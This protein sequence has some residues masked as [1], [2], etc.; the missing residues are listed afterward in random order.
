MKRSSLIILAM[1]A[2]LAGCNGG[3]ETMKDEN[4]SLSV[5]GVSDREARVKIVPS[6]TNVYYWWDVETEEWF[7]EHKDSIG[8][9]YKRQWDEA[10]R[11]GWYEPE[12]G[13]EEEEDGIDLTQGGNITVEDFMYKGVEKEDLDALRPETEYVLFAYYPDADYHASAITVL[14]F[15]TAKAEMVDDMRIW[16]MPKG[17]NLHINLSIVAYDE[18]FY[19]SVSTRD[20]GS[21]S[22][23]EYAEQY[24]SSNIGKIRTETE[25]GIISFMADV[26]IPEDETEWFACSYIEKTRTSKWYFYHTPTK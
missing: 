4:F 14:P 2:V 16:F 23:E 5:S 7:R 17:D 1:A 22:I 21:A 10:I 15:R 9:Y 13:E 8:E 24:F 25:G 12:G 20:L 11:Y 19:G 3:G 6:N 18:L 26:P